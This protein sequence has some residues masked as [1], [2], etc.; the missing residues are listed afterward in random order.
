MEY[1]AVESAKDAVQ[2]YGYNAI[3]PILLDIEGQ[4][5][6]FMSLYGDGYTIKGYAL[7][8]LEDKTIVGTGLVDVAK[9][10]VKALNAAV[11]NYIDALKDKGVVDESA[12]ADDYKADEQEEASS[13]V[14]EA[15][16]PEDKAV[17]VTG[18]ISDIKT[19]VNDGNTVY[20]LQIGDKYYYISVSDCMEVLLLKKGDN[21]ESNETFIPA[22][23]VKIK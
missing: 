20:Y 19:S 12:N 10:D 2:N 9:S 11:S 16:A 5:T 22:K 15:A 21:V 3:F 18:A 13:V 4:P 14:E 6:Y 17:T 8:N 1:S 7:V 23:D